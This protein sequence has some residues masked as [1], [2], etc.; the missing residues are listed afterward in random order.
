MSKGQSELAERIR[1][2]CR[3]AETLRVVE[4]RRGPDGDGVLLGPELHP[5]RGGLAGHGENLVL[6]VADDGSG[7]DGDP[8]GTGLSIV[9]AL[10]RD[11]L[12]GQLTL[13]STQD[14]LRAEVVFP[15]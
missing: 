6:T 9:R 14:G 15:R 11:E 12:R 5:D 10:V 3:I 2:E 7:L 1:T 13:E 8:Q 4:D